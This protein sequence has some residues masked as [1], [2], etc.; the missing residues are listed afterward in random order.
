LLQGSRQGLLDGKQITM[1]SFSA[2]ASRG[3]SDGA[4]KND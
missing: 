4:V 3:N 2:K 1:I